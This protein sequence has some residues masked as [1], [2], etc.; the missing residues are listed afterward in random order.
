MIISYG[1]SVVRPSRKHPNV[2][3]SDY[4]AIYKKWLWEQQGHSRQTRISAASTIP[5][6]YMVL[7]NELLQNLRGTKFVSGCKTQRSHWIEAQNC[8]KVSV[9]EL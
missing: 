3:L 6:S 2:K 9:V 1:A 7:D 4:K 8:V 5:T